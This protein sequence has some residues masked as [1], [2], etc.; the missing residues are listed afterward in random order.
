MACVAAGPVALLTERLE[1]IP[2]STAALDALIK[3]DRAQLEAD[4]TE[5]TKALISWALSR[6]G[7]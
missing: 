1:L 6:T 7:V 3:K 2:L 5:A 4:A